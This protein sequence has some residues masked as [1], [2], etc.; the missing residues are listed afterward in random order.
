MFLAPLH[1]SGAPTAP[2]ALSAAD[3]AAYLQAQVARA[4]RAWREGRMAD[5]A[6]AVDRTL[7]LVASLRKPEVPAIA[8]SRTAA[9]LVEAGEV[10]R[11]LGLYR[12]AGA[13]VARL[14]PPGA[15]A[16]LWRRTEARLLQQPIAADGP[17][18]APGDLRKLARDL[19]ASALAPD[20]A[21]RWTRPSAEDRLRVEQALAQANDLDAETV[22]ILAQ[23]AGRSG[24]NFD[25]D[26]LTLLAQAR[27][28]LQRRTVHQALRLRARRDRL[29]RTEIQRVLAAAA[30]GR[31]APTVCATRPTFAS[32]CA[33]S[34][35]DWPRRRRSSPATA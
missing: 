8:V 26:A 2:A 3:G 17:P 34:T 20:A 31:A 12:A 7:S 22:L 30:A 9:L 6:D 14:L 23:L 1:A 5:F 18:A 16:A 28:A 25:A 15:E 33:T 13:D 24:P 11:A 19:R 35:G 27:D 4:E 10:E 21:R 29:E 32:A